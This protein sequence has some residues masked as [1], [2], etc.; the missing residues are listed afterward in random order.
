MKQYNLN[1]SSNVLLDLLDKILVLN[2]I[3]VLLTNGLL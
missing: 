3:Y 2:C 1:I